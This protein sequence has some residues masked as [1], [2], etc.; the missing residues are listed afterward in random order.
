MSFCDTNIHCHFCRKE[1]DGKQ[2][3]FE[4]NI[5]DKCPNEKPFIGL[6]LENNLT[7]LSQYEIRTNI[8]NNCDRL[9]TG[10]KCLE[11]I[12]KCGCAGKHRSRFLNIHCPI[13]KW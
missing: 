5:P 1:V 3:R 7:N 9:I 13:G 12:K 8:C 4:N 2:W 10:D 6:S 11:F